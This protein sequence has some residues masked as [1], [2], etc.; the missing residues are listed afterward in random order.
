[1]NSPATACG[2]TGWLPSHARTEP[3]GRE[4]FLRTILHTLPL[5][6]CWQQCG[7]GGGC[8]TNESLLRLTGLAREDVG[9]ID[10]LAGA[11]HP[12]DQAAYA[13]GLTQ[14]RTGQADE[15]S[16]ELRCGSGE[17]VSWRQLSLQAHRAPDGQLTDLVLTLADISERKQH[18]NEMR[19]AIESAEALNQ[20]IEI[21]IDRAQQS[22]VEANLA[23]L[24]K[25]Q[26]LATMSH[27]IR[28]PMNGIIGMTDLLME[29][30][31]NREQRDF[32]DTIR[33]S[34]EALLTIINDILDFS[35]IESGKLELEQAD[36]ALRDCVEGALDLM[37]ARAREKHLD[38]LYEIAEGAPA[39]VRGDVTRL[40]Q[41]MLNLV[42]N[43]VKF[44]AKG[45]VVVR[46]EPESGA[47]VAS[48][49]INLHVSV[50]DTGIGIPLEAQDRLFQ[51]FSQV[52][53]S[54]TRKYGGTGLGLAISKK[55][56]ELMGGR[57]W[58]ESN[59]GQGS[60]FHFT[61]TL[62]ARPG[63]ARPNAAV[64]RALL[65]G[66]RVLLVED[67]ATSR[68]IL[69]ELV[70][71]WGM[72]PCAVGAGEEALAVLRAGRA[73]DIAILDAQMPGMDG[74]TL[75]R[76][77]HQ[78]R[79]AEKLPV[80]LMAALGQRVPEGVAATGVAKPV[81][82]IALFEALAAAFG[83]PGEAAVPVLPVQTVV[84]PVQTTR[85]LLAEDNAV[86]QKVAVNLLKNIGYQTE[87]VGNG[88]EALA[89]VARQAYD[90]IF[91]DMQ[92]PEMD[93]L[94]AAR[95]LVELYP[96][97]ENRPWMIAL[98]ANAMQGDRELC[99]A[100]G[101]DDYVTKPIKKIE[102]AAAIERGRAA[103]AGRTSSK[104]LE[105]G[106]PHPAN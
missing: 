89:A 51:S 13:A 97:P 46:I 59:P 23:S 4:A 66:R 2:T 79:S 73:F 58:V 28:T 56:A 95:R 60:T 8:W 104:A 93:G 45:E 5:G 61:I 76:N 102:L 44:T 32:A 7:A 55:L 27:E 53:A 67:N 87:V 64:A 21:A 84:T 106:C 80:L 37:A 40:R 81:K 85:L 99:L 26:F 71:R 57:M 10:H 35:K 31:L 63:S 42:G 12:E 47:L 82:A 34:G 74:A 33:I 50:R 100:A 75:A 52:D 18:Q 1:M 70:L 68:Q 96:R 11:I 29:S 69:T 39:M 88:R 20:Q 16:V 25:S 77:I 43:A 65:S 101:M 24:S 54:T 72:E 49:P 14:L 30:P 98:T 48:G 19:M 94:E 92:M 17:E 36:F 86:N 9:T 78:V 38:L 15:F 83:R 91:L 6:V 103:I 3:A 22:A 105:A 41:I 62:A 90:I